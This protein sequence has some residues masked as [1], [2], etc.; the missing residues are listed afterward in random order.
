MLQLCI[1]YAAWWSGRLSSYLVPWFSTAGF[2]VNNIFI[3][4]IFPAYSSII[5]R[6]FSSN[7][8]RFQEFCRALSRPASVWNW[9]T[10]DLCNMRVVSPVPEILEVN[11]P[12]SPLKCQYSDMFLITFN[13]L[14]LL[15]WIIDTGN[16]GW[17][18]IRR[19]LVLFWGFQPIFTIKILKFYLLFVVNVLK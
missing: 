16:W 13:L 5:K 1:L 14:G 11:A 2:F 7:I 3:A 10:S 19:C 12:G 17:A 8:Y 6:C 15:F 18:L 9:E 4:W